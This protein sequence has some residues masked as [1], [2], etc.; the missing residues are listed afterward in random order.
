[1]QESN[2]SP[3]PLEGYYI[4]VLSVGVLSNQSLLSPPRF[5]EGLQ[6]R[7]AVLREYKGQSVKG[8]PILIH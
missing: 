8:R 6:L 3:M 5:Y 2:F 7:N 1:M 4:Y